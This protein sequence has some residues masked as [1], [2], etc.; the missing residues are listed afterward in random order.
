MESS[1]PRGLPARHVDEPAFERV[2]VAADPTAQARALRVDELRRRHAQFMDELNCGACRAE[3]REA[4]A[5][6]AR[7]VRLQVAG[8]YDAPPDP[9]ITQM[10]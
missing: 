6:G 7:T 2:A 5:R 4:G 1:L 8:R 10:T 9:T 3:E